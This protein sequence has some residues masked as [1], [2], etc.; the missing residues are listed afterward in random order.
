VHDGKENGLIKASGVSM[1]IKQL[2]QREVKSFKLNNE[3][4]RG[5]FNSAIYT[6]TQGKCFSART[7]IIQKRI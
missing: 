2:N 7:L 6:L 3:T 5:L 4:W 1:A